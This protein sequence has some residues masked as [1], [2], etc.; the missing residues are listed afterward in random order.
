M[1]FL[2]VIA[3]GLLALPAPRAA[4]A[5]PKLDVATLKKVKAATVHLQVKVPDG[6]VLQGSGF[7]TDEPGL[8][9]TN[10][11][12]LNMLD[13]ESRKPVRVDVTIESGTDRS[14]TCIGQVLGVDRG[15]DLGL[16]RVEDK[17]LPQPLKLGDVNEL[18]E[19]E[20]VYVFGFPFG[21]DL[22][23]EIT[24][25]LSTVSSLRK[26]GAFI[27]KVQLEGGLNPGNSGGPVVNGK[28]HVVGVAVCGVR[29]SKIGFAVPANHITP[30]LNG[31][32]SGSG[33]G[34]PFKEGGGQK[35]P[36]SLDV[37]DPLGRVKMLAVEVWTGNSGPSR[38]PNDKEPPALP[39]DSPA[40]RYELKYDKKPRVSMDV[41]VPPLGPNKVY[42]IRPV[43]TNGLG[44]TRWLPGTIA[45]TGQPLER[46]AITMKFQ[47]PVGAKQTAELT[48]LGGFR[49]RTQEGEDHSLDLNFR[50]TVTENFAAEEDRC[51]PMRLTYNRFTMNI[52]L[53][54]E[55]QE[56]S[57]TLRN[58]LQNMRFLAA[59]VEMDRD[60]SLSGAKANL[61]RVPKAS[62]DVLGDISEQILQSLEVLSIPVPAKQI[63]ASDTWKARRNFRIGSAIVAVP[64]QADIVYTYLGLQPS[65]GEELVMIAIDGRLKGR[66]GDGV[67]VGGTINGTAWLSPE[68]GQV[69]RANTQIKADLDLVFAKKRARAICTLNVSIKRPAPSVEKK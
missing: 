13:P 19:T 49:I 3:G 52:K 36:V 14:R 38:P 34:T 67:D 10:A 44:V 29:G 35:L 62:R 50:T 32:I 68:T 15:S 63:E 51:F 23:K 64:A 30:F 56:A 33:I 59:D 4:W 26:S 58:S 24:V 8:I 1:W 61:T 42:W 45:R 11:H 66:R 53:D 57:D 20:T 16:I 5:G 6:R 69:V 27:S 2:F 48:S 28:G 46:K 37:I 65:G 7:F 47:P 25:A 55:V 12:V 22:G 21:K 9:V 54:G 39:S 17:D 40:K 18:L 43:I 41:S 31:R 60:G